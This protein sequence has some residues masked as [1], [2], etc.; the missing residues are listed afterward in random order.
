ML[1]PDSDLILNFKKDEMLFI[2]PWKNSFE[3]YE[4]VVVKNVMNKIKNNQPNIFYIGH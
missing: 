3:T 4:D 2:V 1:D